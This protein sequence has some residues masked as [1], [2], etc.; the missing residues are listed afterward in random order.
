MTIGTETYK[1]MTA[2]VS[3]GI[4]EK[5][6]VSIENTEPKVGDTLTAIV[7]PDDAVVT[8]SW[9]AGDTVVGTE[10]NLEVTADMLGKKIKVKV[11]A[12]NSDTATSPETAAV[13]YEVPKILTAVRKAANSFTLNFDS[14]ARDIVKVDDIV[15]ISEDKTDVKKITGLDF[16]DRK[17]VV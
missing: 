2:A 6:A 9:T 14:D 11:T 7:T 15:V 4:A 17:S 5:L 1:A 16:E 8:Y 10:E 12:L 3:E 13:E